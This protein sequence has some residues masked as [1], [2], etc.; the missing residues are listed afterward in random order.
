MRIDPAVPRSCGPTQD[1][2]TGQEP[3]ASLVVEAFFISRG[4]LRPI[5][6]NGLIL[7]IDLVALPQR[8]AL[9]W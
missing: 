1:R 8:D 5:N 7:F 4:L 9:E 3:F 2:E 6:A